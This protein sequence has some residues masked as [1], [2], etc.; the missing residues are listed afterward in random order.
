MSGGVEGRVLKGVVPPGESPGRALSVDPLGNPVHDFFSRNVMADEVNEA[1]F[2][3]GEDFLE[4]FEDQSIDEKMVH[5]REVGSE[6]HVIEVG[7]SL[8]RSK[9]S[10]NQLLVAGGIGN[11]PLLEV[12]FEGLELSLGEIVSEST[13]SAVGKEG[14]LSVLQAEDFSGASGLG[15]FSYGDF[16]GFSEVVTTTVRAKLSGLV[17][18][19][20]IVSFTEH[21]RESFFKGGDTT[22]VT[23]V[24]AVFASLRPLDGNPESFANL[25]GSTL[26]GGFLAE[27]HID[28]TT[29]LGVSLS[30]TGSG[31]SS[32]ADGGDELTSDSL[33]R[34]GI[35]VDVELK[36]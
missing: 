36:E 21:S 3:S 26:G 9:R 1:S 33:V 23:E 24:S 13:R 20:R 35:V 5:G 2:A 8:G 19:T 16:F 32:L 10:V 34:D 25:L 15:R 12:R 28:L 31:G 4:G 14:D 18:E 6:G 7:I 29:F 30:S 27:I 22:I 17:E 11:V